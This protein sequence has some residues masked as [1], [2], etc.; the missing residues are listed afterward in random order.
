M[1]RSSRLTYVSYRGLLR[2]RLGH[3]AERAVIEA[4]IRKVDGLLPPRLSNCPR[5]E[6][7]AHKVGEEVIYMAFHDPTCKTCF[8]YSAEDLAER[9][10]VQFGSN[11]QRERARRSGADESQAGSVR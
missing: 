6:V 4:A 2:G 10:R 1:A 11:Q 9:I 7:W 3:P 8:G 5:W